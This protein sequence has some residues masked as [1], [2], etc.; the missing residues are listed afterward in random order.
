MTEP[1]APRRGLLYHFFRRP[2]WSDWRTWALLIVLAS[3]LA[4]RIVAFSAT[5]SSLFQD[6]DG[7]WGLAHTLMK[8]GNYAS[9]LVASPTAFRPPL[10]PLLLTPVAFL[11]STGLKFFMPTLIGLLQI[12][13]GMI[14]VWLTYRVSQRLGLGD[15]SLL[16]AL[17]VAVDPILL[18]YTTQVMTE[19]FAACLAAWLLW[20]CVPN[21]RAASSKH[22]V[23]E[24]KNAELTVYANRYKSLNWRCAHW[25]GTGIVLGLCILCRPAFAVFGILTAAVWIV[26]NIKSL[27][28]DELLWLQGGAVLVGLSLVMSPWVIRNYVVMGQPVILTTHGGYTLLLGNNPVFYKEVVQQPMG[29]VWDGKSLREWQNEMLGSYYHDQETEWLIA[30]KLDVEKRYFAPAVDTS[31]SNYELKRDRWN[32]NRA[33]QNIADQPVLF[34]RAC[35]LR[36]IRFWSPMPLGP[37]AAGMPRV[38]LSAVGL[39]YIAIYAAALIGVWAIV[40]KRRVEFLAPLLLILAFTALHTVYWSNARMRAPVMPA[41]ALLVAVGGDFSFSR[42][43]AK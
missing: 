39:W 31:S 17:V 16:A 9:T 42:R 15:W 23:E 4:G 22:E 34:L 12:M 19:V 27:R 18:R 13:L 35:L 14:T 11:E 2:N 29:T 6:P 3:A 28:S 10:Y 26:R 40:W 32:R 38:A 24:G 36:V 7:Y 5:Y 37:A 20:I 1:T 43:K 33:L 8:R 25:A 41:I 21:Q 30:N